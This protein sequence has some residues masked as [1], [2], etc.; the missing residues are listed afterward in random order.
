MSGG[1]GP[2]LLDFSPLA[3]L[4][5]TFFDARRAATKSRLEEAELEAPGKFAT[6]QA[7]GG[8]ALGTAQSDTTPLN[9]IG[10]AQPAQQSQPKLPTF[11][12]LSGTQPTAKLDP[13]QAAK[14]AFDT[15]V[16]GGLTPG[17]AAGFVGNFAEESS[18]NPKA[19]NAKEGAIG[20]AQW[21]GPRAQALKQ[22]AAANGGDPFDPAIQAKFALKEMSTDPQYAD[23]WRRLQVAKTPQEAA[24]AVIHWE[25][26]GGWKPGDATG[27]PSYADRQGHAVRV[28]QTFGGG[29]ASDAPAPG[30]QEA[31]GFIVP[32]ARQPSSATPPMLEIPQWLQKAAN[33]PN[34]YVRQ[35]ATKRIEAYQDAQRQ[36]AVRQWERQQDTKTLDLGTE[37]GVMDGQ[38]NIVRRIPKQK[39]QTPQLVG[40]DETGRAWVKP[41]DPLP[42]NL[43]K[44]QTPKD[45]YEL[46]KGKNGTPIGIYDK[47]E[48][49]QLLPEEAQQRGIQPGAPAQENA[50]DFKD[51]SG[52]RKEIQDLPAYKSYAS[53]IPAYTSMLDAAKRN[54]KTADL[55]MVY[56]LAKI[57]DPTSVVR[58]G[59]IQMANDTQGIADRLNGFIQSIQGEGRLAPETRA[60]LVQEA[61]SRMNGFK[62]SLDA[63]L[64]QFRGFAQRWKINE[65]D[66]IPNL[67]GMPQYDPR[68]FNTIS[69]TEGAGS[70]HGTRAIPE[71]YTAGRVLSDAK[72]AYKKAAQQS[73]PVI[74]KYQQDAIRNRLKSFKIDPSRL[75][76]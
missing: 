30:A 48:G 31:Q 32:G 39:D 70:G 19:Y 11:A 28:A 24:D 8:S 12:A 4:A 2:P 1:Y 5:K 61:E 21:R 6:Y 42:E 44:P 46:I 67:P 36:F 57:M 26:P 14:V 27:V 62:Q 68:E 43:S 38:G 41:G 52:I 37:V 18:Y 49:R 73:D 17:Q 54:T 69:K 60:G 22:F 55:N 50:P 13:N 35:Q 10:Q 15:L 56:A 72:E 71:G 58:E 16:S 63:D 29:S 23:A 47:I 53:A 20:F 7:E 34:P 64:G 66:I 3:N 65:A 25:K 74:R 75:D 33:D 40:T 9:A 76:E 51:I 59:E 45:R